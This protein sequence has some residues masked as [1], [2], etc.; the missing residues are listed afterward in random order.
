MRTLKLVWGFGHPGNEATMAKWV[1]YICFLWPV[2]LYFTVNYVLLP[3]RF[4]ATI[5]LNIIRSVFQAYKQT[6]LFEDFTIPAP[7][8]P[9]IS[10]RN[11]LVPEPVFEPNQTNNAEEDTGTF[12]NTIQ[13]VGWQVI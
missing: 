11:D 8:D 12:V 9:I 10:G 3:F 7:S 13:N 2:L 5:S 1:L 6:G 4:I